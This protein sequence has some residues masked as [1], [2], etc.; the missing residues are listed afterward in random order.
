MT[1]TAGAFAFLGA[2]VVALPLGCGARTRLHGAEP[3]RFEDEVTGCFGVCGEGTTRCVDGFWSAC[4][5]PFQVE[6]CTNN[7]GEG[8]RSCSD[9]VWTECDVPRV[10]EACQNNCG[11]GTWFCEDNRWSECAVAP[12]TESCTNDCGTGT[13]LCEE[14]TWSECDVRPT[15]RECSFGCGGGTE[16]CTD[17]EWGPCDAPR[18]LPPVLPATIRDFSASHPDFESDF[19][20]VDLGIVEDQLGGDGKPVYRSSTTT[21]TTTGED[22]FNQWYRDVPGVNQST[23]IELVLSP[24]SFDEDFYVYSN[25]AFF[26]IDNQL[27]GNEGYDHNYHFTLEAEAQFVYESGQVFRFDGDDDIFVFIN[28]FL[29][30]DIGGLH[31]SLQAEVALDDVAERLGIT[32]GGKYQLK[33]FF[34]ERHTVESN[35]VIETSISDLGQCPEEP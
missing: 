6:P 30:I 3:C 25:R 24:S 4:E 33:I 8:T 13:R 17:N 27:L 29:V 5:I 1:R 9:E 23:E 28:G 12:V 31:Q 32:P 19:A 16:T 35:F 14:D 18:P 20:G 15:T 10:E 26:P 2:L 7:C 22:N 21:P 34:A 11:R